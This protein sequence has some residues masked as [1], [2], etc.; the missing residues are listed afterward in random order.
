MKSLHSKFPPPWNDPLMYTLPENGKSS[1]RTA[2]S[3][4]GTWIALLLRNTHFAKAESYHPQT[5]AHSVSFSKL[6]V[7]IN[8][9]FRSPTN[10]GGPKQILQWPLKNWGSNV[11]VISFWNVQLL[12][13]SLRPRGN[14]SYQPGPS[15]IPW[16]FFLSSV[17]NRPYFVLHQMRMRKEK[18][19]APMFTM[20]I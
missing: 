1:F 8:P 6:T 16:S 18:F 5:H 2:A 10:T 17:V 13:I 20:F 19:T 11:E 12:F 4:K 15:N 14:A 7:F 9:T 3:W